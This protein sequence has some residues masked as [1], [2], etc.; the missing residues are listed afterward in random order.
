MELDLPLSI[1]E[2]VINDS[3]K[4][5]EEGEYSPKSSIITCEKCFSIPKITIL[6]KNE[7]S[8]SCPKC[9]ASTIKDI[10][11]FDKFFKKL[12][13][14]A[15]VNLPKCS[16]NLEHKNKSDKYCF[17]C[18]KYLCKECIK[19]HNISFKDKNHILIGQKM[20]NKYY[21]DKKG[22]T[23]Y[24]YNRFCTKCND[25]LCSKCKCEHGIQ[26]IYV[27]DE[28]ENIQKIFDIEEKVKECEKIIE[29]EEKKL[30]DLLKELKN[31]IKTLTKMF[32]KYKERN[33]K[34][35]SFYKLLI[36]NF[37]QINSI[38]NYNL[39]NNIILN[40]DF[41]LCNSND[42]S[43]KENYKY[44]GDECLSS[45]YNKL[46]NFYA[47]KNHIK[48]KQYTEY[49]ITKKFC[50]KNAV[51]KCISIDN[52][53]IV[54]IFENSQHIYYLYK[55]DY[56]ENCY[57]YEI[58]KTKTDD[59]IKDIYPL[60]DNKF[61]VLYHLNKVNIWKI[62]KKMLYMISKNEND[63]LTNINNVFIDEFDRNNFFLIQS[64]E[65]LLKIKYYYKN[66]S[67]PS[68]PS[69]FHII[70]IYNGNLNLKYIF[71][72]IIEVII[73]SDLRDEDKTLLT[74]L[75]FESNKNLNMENLYKLDE[76][77]LNFI[78]EKIQKLYSTIKD[79]IENDDEKNK[80]IFNS[81]YIYYK[82]ITEL[83]NNNKLNEKE[84]ELIKYFVKFYK[85]IL[86]IKDIYNHYLVLNS[87]INNIYNFNN[88]KIIL[89]G[90][91]FLFMTLTLNNRELSSLNSL[92]FLPDKDINYNNY[93]I[94]SIFNDYIILNDFEKKIIYIILDDCL[95]L[96]KKKYKYF[97][98]I[99][100]DNNYLIFDT[101]KENSLQFEFI[102]LNNNLESKNHE[103]KELF[104]FKIN[105]NIPKFLLSFKNNTFLSIYDNN[106]INII[107][108]TLL[109]N[110]E[111]NDIKTQKIKK[112]EVFYKDTPWEEQGYQIKLYKKKIIPEI[113]NYSSIYENNYHPKNLFTNDD[114]YYS[115]SLGLDHFIEFDFGEEYYFVEFIIR[116]SDR[117]IK[118]KPTNYKIQAYD[119]K[120]RLINELKFVC[121]LDKTIYINSLNEKARYMKFMFSENFG[122]EYIVIKKLEFYRYNLALI[123]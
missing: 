91:K 1:S 83:R 21:C 50:N 79:K 120:K 19:I 35:I 49:I 118:C 29:N 14:K 86:S 47:N 10:S 88:K 66:D 43:I 87:K 78:D 73:F 31:K 34:I 18:T 68:R 3:D 23:E 119:G 46:C 101:V 13:E 11:Y 77:L 71:D 39:Y 109:R 100:V 44:D 85:V 58:I 59:I 45:K 94:K 104:K 54:F 33:M 97:K 38:R 4:T 123:K 82:I 63:E 48:T 36:D 81:H 26:N 92:N 111:K 90:E 72:D 64:N 28:I 110:E 112:L 80:Y 55:N 62:E 96:L 98:S 42:F 103:L 89:M 20:E 30:N 51:K 41:D 117:Y 56:P 12:E 114:L 121:E 16:Y 5:R 95:Y 122:G 7:V 75:I 17:Q 69:D 8:I 24:I 53:K 40:G 57:G 37:Y 60:K 61:L 2:S 107:S 67:F 74:K 116:F 9:K 25:Y 99:I 27:F 32:D 102:D 65:N 105:S 115:S 70:F 22:H 106:Q 93:E 6:K 84:I 108:Y 76:N 15:F 113:R 52:E